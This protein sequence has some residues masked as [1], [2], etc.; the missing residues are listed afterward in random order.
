MIERE[1]LKLNTSINTASNSQDLL[2]DENGNIEAKIS[3]VLPANLIGNTSSS[4][5]K[6]ID[7]IALQT[8][9]FRLSL[10]NTPIAQMPLD[11]DKK[12]DSLVPSKCQVD[13]YPYALLDNS[14]LRPEVGNRDMSFPYYKNHTVTYT[15][16]I[17]NEA[18]QEYVFQA[19]TEKN[20]FP[21]SSV[22]YPLFKEIGILN[23]GDHIM[24]ICAQ[25][26]HE[27]FHVENDVLY[28][29]NIG[30]IEQMLQDGIENAI[31]YASTSSDSKFVIDFYTQ[32]YEG[33]HPA[34]TDYHIDYYNGDIYYAGYR[35]VPNGDSS[36]DSHVSCSLVKACKPSVRIGEQSLTISYDTAAFDDT[37]PIFWNTPFVNTY[38][39]PEQLTVDHY[40]KT[41]WNIPPPKRVYKYGV[42]TDSTG[43]YNFILD[44][45]MNCAVMNLIVN[46]SLRDTMS[47]LPWIKLDLKNI[48]GVIA[49][50][51]KYVNYR[52]LITTTTYTPDYTPK[53]FQYQQEARRSYFT[54]ENTFNNTETRKI[55]RRTYEYLAIQPEDYSTDIGTPQN[56]IDMVHAALEIFE[57]RCDQNEADYY[58]E[59]AVEFA[60]NNDPWCY[61]VTRIRDTKYSCLIKFKKDENDD[62]VYKSDEIV[63]KMNITPSYANGETVP[64]IITSIASYT[65]TGTKNLE[66]YQSN[67][68][69]LNDTTKNLEGTGN[70]GTAPQILDK[71][72]NYT[73]LNGTQKAFIK[74]PNY[75]IENTVDNETTIIDTD[76]TD[77]KYRTYLDPEQESL[78]LKYMHYQSDTNTTNYA[79][80]RYCVEKHDSN[81]YIRVYNIKQILKDYGDFLEYYY[82][83]MAAGETLSETDG[84]QKINADV[85]VGTNSYS[86]RE[87][88]DTRDIIN[89]ET[90]YFPN[91]DMVN[92]N[93]YILDGTSAEISIGPQEPVIKS[94]EVKYEYDTRI[95]TSYQVYSERT[96]VE[97][98][99]GTPGVNDLNSSTYHFV[100][101]TGCQ[102]VTFYADGTM[103][104]VPNKT[105]PP[106]VS[107]VTDDAHYVYLL[108]LNITD[109]STDETT[110]YP[111]VIKYGDEQSPLQT[112]VLEKGFIRD[113]TGTTAFIPV[114]NPEQYP[115]T[116]SKSGGKY[117]S[118]VNTLNID[119]IVDVKT[120]DRELFISNTPISSIPTSFDQSI[121]IAAF[122]IYNQNSVNDDKYEM[123]YYVFGDDNTF[124]DSLRDSKGNII[125]PIYDDTAT[126]R[127]GNLVKNWFYYCYLLKTDIDS[128][129]SNGF[130]SLVDSYNT[131]TYRDVISTPIETTYINDVPPITKY[132]N[133]EYDGNLRIT[134]IWNN[135]PMVVM[136]PIQSIVLTLNGVQITHEIQPVNM[137][138]PSGSSLVTTIPIVENFYSLA[139]TLRD[140]HDELVVT[141]ETFDDSATY[142]LGL[143]AGQE[144]TL[145]FSAKYI[146][147]DGALHQIYIPPNGVFTLQLTFGISYYIS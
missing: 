89:N 123:M 48:N 129:E 102:N 107:G 35:F 25:S 15:I 26:N 66:T 70:G 137:Q 77:I 122:M 100:G 118:S 88:S 38:D 51:Q 6:K 10:E 73:D 19:N 119:D 139:Q 131:N 81:H 67:I 136:S 2:K 7:S 85:Y 45:D 108:W 94:L 113:T 28:I 41:V 17:N 145:T 109:T 14:E 96:R 60:R 99:Y 121:G 106:S 31:T 64:E 97:K 61:C 110:S 63:S 24:N 44:H 33:T 23:L 117:I 18:V 78:Y 62:I 9:K 69:H 37:I 141:K 103:H 80:N 11:T 115:P 130:G 124:H 59:T 46:Q 29:H 76:S 112:D 138:Q 13:V 12:T 134:Y 42:S 98:Q 144:R 8:S 146:T 82:L 72:F 30:T 75:R 57:K 142:T 74:M 27:A 49:D 116:T 52:D 55:K 140:L 125:D 34:L 133:N 83:D 58:D 101:C 53:T 4:S 3:L 120:M 54:Q 114:Q 111:A 126:E 36:D 1:Y 43:V 135:L 22:F 21:T 40:R 104:T 16:A 86:M 95:D 65:T 87:H 91:L 90:V 5:P 50:Q 71:L 132:Q 105:F 147:K 79:N 39:T 20:G 68:Q 32:D 128:D 93:F 56:V 92:N 127:D 143:Q 47:F 84:T